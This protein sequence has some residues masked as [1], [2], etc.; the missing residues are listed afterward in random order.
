MGVSV[1]AYSNAGSQ[2][3]SKHREWHD[4]LLVVKSRHI[5]QQRGGPRMKFVLC[6][7]CMLALFLKSDQ[8]ESP[9]TRHKGINGGI[10]CAGRLFK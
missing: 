6:V 2:D 9:F 10:A 8:L 3:H 7:L 4:D 5:K 1:M